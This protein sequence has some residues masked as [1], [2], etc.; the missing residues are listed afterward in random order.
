MEG[1]QRGRE[2]GL[3]HGEPRAAANEILPGAG[4]YAGRTCAFLDDGDPPSRTDVHR[5]GHQ[6]RL[7]GRPST[8]AVSSSP[9]PIV[10]DFEGRSLRTPSSSSRFLRRG[11]V[12]EQKF[13]PRSDALR[14]QHSSKDV[15]GRARVAQA[16]HERRRRPK[17]IEEASARG[18]DGIGSHRVAGCVTG[19]SGS[20]SS[21]TVRLR[22][23]I[24]VRGIPIGR[25][26]SPPSQRANFWKLLLVLVG[27]RST[28]LSVYLR[29]LTLAAPDRPCWRPFETQRPSVR[30]DGSIGF[31]A[32]NLLPLRIGR[33]HPLV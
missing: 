8:T 5:C 4:V 3:P 31:L 13:D 26:S 33:D 23:G 22:S 30:A 20:G 16:G 1:M 7:C 11:Y 24:A 15:D 28:S 10:I 27:S 6:R 12:A 9:R 17:P 25:G 14:E 2:H 21:I 18:R 29:A 32:N 19:A